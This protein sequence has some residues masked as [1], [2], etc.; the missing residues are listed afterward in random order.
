MIFRFAYAC[1]VAL[2]LVSVPQSAPAELAIVNARVYTGDAARPWAEAISIQTNRI[3]AVGTTRRD[4]GGR[5]RRARST[6]AA[7]CS[8]RASTTRTRIPGAMPPATRLEG[9]P[10]IEHDPTLDEVIA[11]IKTGGPELAGGTLDRR[12]DRRRRARRS[13]RDARDARS[14]HRRSAA[15]ARAWTGHGADLQYR[16]ACARSVSR[17]GAGSARRLVRPRRRRPDA[18]RSRARIRRLRSSGS[19]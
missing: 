15:D 10:A 19:G 1:A 12:G 6:P 14:A 9:P 4:Q 8:S 17:D 7:G 13:A 11:R 18:H 16:R 3:A 5:A 2:S